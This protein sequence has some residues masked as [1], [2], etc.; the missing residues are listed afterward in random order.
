MR[1]ID[2]NALIDTVE[3]LD[4]YHINK[5]GYLVHGAN[6]SDH[7]PIYKAESIYR[8]IENAPT[9]D[10]VPV[11]RCKDCMRRGTTDCPMLEAFKSYPFHEPEDDAFCSYGVACHTMKTVSQMMDEPKIKTHFARIVVCGTEQNPYY[12]ILYYDPADKEY[13]IGYGSYCISFVRQWLAEE[14]EITPGMNE[15]VVHGEWISVDGTPECDEWDCSVCERRLT[16]GELLN[17]EDVYEWN[18]YC[19]D[20]GAK[21]DGGNEE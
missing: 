7:T 5:K 20:C 1:L 13:H 10:A 4:W 21:M 12:N 2:A 3:G 9:V 14:F 18:H 8:A 19:P 11:V 15:P 6:S 16:F 17:A